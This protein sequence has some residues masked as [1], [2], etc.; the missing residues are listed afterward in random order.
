MET[1]LES[2]VEE[3]TRLRG[4]LNDL[5][6]IMALPVL[7]TGGEPSRIASTLLDALV[8]MLR[9]SFAFIRLNDAE[10]GPSIEMARVPEP[11]EDST[12]ERDIGEALNVSLGDTPLNWPPSARVSI[13][14]VESSIASTRLGL[15]GELGVV[16]VGSQRAGFPRQTEEL[17]LA[18]AANQA[19]MGLQQALLLSEQKRAS[20][21][22][23]RRVAQRT[24]ELAT[25]KDES[26]RSEHES[27]AAYR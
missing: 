11:L 16:V 8:R 9:L 21:E 13:G 18:V 20:R 3:I 26:E 17:L 2:P 5:V 14:D 10:G 4:C 23:D 6:R 24:R 15:Q 7:G 22:L 27:L 12:C 25:A 19:A 1:P